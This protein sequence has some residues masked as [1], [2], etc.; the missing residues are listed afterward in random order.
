[1]SLRPASAVDP[2]IV[3]GCQSS[4]P[5]VKKCSFRQVGLASFCR[6]DLAS[7]GRVGRARGFF[8][9]DRSGPRSTVLGRGHTRHIDGRPSAPPPVPCMCTS[10]GGRARRLHEQRRLQAC[11]VC[12]LRCFVQSSRGRANYPDDSAHTRCVNVGRRALT[13]RWHAPSLTRRVANRAPDRGSLRQARQLRSRL[14][15]ARAFR[16]HVVPQSLGLGLTAALGSK[17]RQVAPGHVPVDPLI[18]GL[19]ESASHAASPA[20]GSV[21]VGADDL[22]TRLGAEGPPGL[23]AHA[24]FD[25]SHRS[26]KEA[27]VH[28]PRVIRAG[29][30]H[31]V[32]FAGAGVGEPAS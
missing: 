31:C 30:D 7:F 19:A 10:C 11:R 17:A 22:A 23:Q 3:K 15:V 16:K 5:A 14:A 13:L 32:V 2:L 26:V 8:T 12:N 6:V 9:R 20:H 28:T 24:A 18:E 21:A 1:M 27:H 25:E 4:S 29:T